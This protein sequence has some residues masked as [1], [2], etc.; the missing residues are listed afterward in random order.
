MKNKEI[1]YILQHTKLN[2]YWINNIL[3]GLSDSAQKCD[4]TTRELSYETLDDEAV[5]NVVLVIGSDDD[6][7]TDTCR[8]LKQLEAEPVVVNA[9]LPSRMKSRV[10][11]VVFEISEAVRGAMSYLSN[12]GK[13][14]ICLVGLRKSSAADL[15]KFEAFNAYIA[16]NGIV[17]EAIFSDESIDRCVREFAGREG[18]FDALLCS[19]DTVALSLMREDGV[20]SHCRNG[21]LYIVGMGDSYIGQYGELSLTTIALDYVEMG[22]Q[23]TKLARL[24]ESDEEPRHIVISLPCRIIPRRTT[25]F[26][27]FGE[28]SGVVSD[29]HDQSGRLES[30]FADDMSQKIIIVED[31]MQKSDEIDRK[32]IY[33]IADGMSCGQISEMV[34]LTDRAVRYRVNTLCRKLEVKSSEELTALLRAVFGLRQ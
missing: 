5:G 31:I 29:T 3:L 9:C 4:Y 15:L 1:L 17:G 18:E 26:T 28:A 13:R 8:Q 2:S 7:V 22:R 30:Y 6:W 24:I 21:R 14:Q 10:S 12:C 19:N 20:S 16:E 27:P 25:E 34:W 32:I 11:A 33:S 23:A